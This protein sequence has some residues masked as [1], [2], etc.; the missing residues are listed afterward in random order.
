[1]LDHDY[2]RAA[3]IFRRVG[4]VDEGYAQLLDG[5]RLLAEGRPAEADVRLREAIGLWRALEATAYVRRAEELL[6]GAGL[7]IPA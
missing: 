7:E 1:V 2:E 4:H 6:A 5:E 3:S